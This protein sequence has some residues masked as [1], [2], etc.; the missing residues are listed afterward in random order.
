[1]NPIDATLLNRGLSWR[2]YRATVE[3]NADVFD[4][5]YD[6]PGFDDADL[7]PLHAVPP[8]T[9]V[10][11]G[12][13]WCPDV[14]HTL[15]A[16]VRVAE[17]LPGWELKIFPRDQH[18]QLMDAFLYRGRAR[19]VPVYAFY[20]RRRYLQTWWSG[21]SAEAQR[22]VDGWL[23]GRTFDQLEPAERAALGKRLDA[24]YRERFRR[25]NFDEIL[26]LL[27]AFFH[28]GPDGAGA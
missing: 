27:K 20:D 11:I 9:V 26:A 17:R 23:A 19:R 25:A 14:Y 8:L 5:V 15:P 24:G 13:D 10:A 18:P 4:R 2:E 3:K 1:M 28:L 12:E 16:W 7:A 22:A 21:R 6:D